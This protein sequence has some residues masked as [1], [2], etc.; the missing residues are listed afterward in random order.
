MAASTDCPD[1]PRGGSR[2]GEEAGSWIGVGEDGPGPPIPVKDCGANGPDIGRRERE[3]RVQ[4]VPRGARIGTDHNLPL[5]PIPVLCQCLTG[6]GGVIPGI[7]DGPG[8]PGREGR[9]PVEGCVHSRDIG[10]RNHF[11]VRAHSCGLG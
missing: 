3:D 9:D 7:A 5:L 6:S 1:I 8:I 2:E 11:P 10:S 4:P